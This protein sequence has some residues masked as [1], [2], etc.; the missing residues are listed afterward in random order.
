M[1]DRRVSRSGIKTDLVSGWVVRYAGVRI[2]RM[3][4]LRLRSA[5]VCR[6]LSCRVVSFQALIHA[7]IPWFLRLWGAA[8]RLLSLVM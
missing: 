3:G 7:S 4:G 2:V 8:V 1:Y 5:S 6:V